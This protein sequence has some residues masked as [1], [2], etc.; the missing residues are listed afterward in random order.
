MILKVGRKIDDWCYFDNVQRVNHFYVKNYGI[1]YAGCDSD[2]CF[3]QLEA[4]LI[5]TH[6]DRDGTD[7]S[8][9]V[10]RNSIFGWDEM[11][12]DWENLLS[13][14]HKTPNPEDSDSKNTFWGFRAIGVTYKNGDTKI[15]LVLRNTPVFL[16]NDEGKTIERL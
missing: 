6:S 16:L 13:Q 1:A 5:N 11:L 9:T 2:G 4:Y 10:N 12:F 3:P 7:K 15:Y 14:I 8:H